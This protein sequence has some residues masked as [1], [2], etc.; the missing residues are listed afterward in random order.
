MDGAIYTSG[1]YR[2]MNTQMYSG[3]HKPES[4]SRN[5][6]L[7]ETNTNVKLN[8]LLLNIL[9]NVFFYQCS[10]L[11]K[12]EEMNKNCITEIQKRFL[13]VCCVPCHAL[14]L[15]NIVQKGS[16]GF[17]CRTTISECSLSMSE[18][19]DHI[20]SLDFHR[21]VLCIRS[22]NY[23]GKPIKVRFP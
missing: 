6:C 1:I 20:G 7:S 18:V 4:S 8:Y 23:R 11:K 10:K 19:Y 3:V 13:S 9:Y 21:Y 12:I 16:T 2:Y 22:G 5:S 15:D 17:F 14:V